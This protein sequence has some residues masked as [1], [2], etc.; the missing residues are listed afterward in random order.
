MQRKC[1]DGA[2]V[3]VVKKSGV[4]KRILEEEH[5]ALFSHCYG[6][7]LNLAASNLVK[8]CKGVS[9]AL[10]TTFV[11]SQ[12]IKFSP[13]HETPFHKLKD[14]LDHSQAQA[15]VYEYFAPHIGVCMVKVCR[16]W[17]TTILF[18][19]RNGRYAWTHN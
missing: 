16:V 18:Y 12:L 2:R 7:S 14:E 9:D 3:M 10:S 15:G 13:K 4:A 8:E 5:R 19:K 6:H 17:L 11:I 1:Y